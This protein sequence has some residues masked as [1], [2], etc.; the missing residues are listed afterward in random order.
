[1][2]LLL[3]LGE[4]MKF[5]L[6][7]FFVFVWIVLSAAG[8][9]ALEDYAGR[10]AELDAK[11][12]GDLTEVCST[13]VVSWVTEAV[14]CKWQLNSTDEVTPWF[15]ELASSSS[16]SWK[17]LYGLAFGYC[18]ARLV[19]EDEMRTQRVRVPIFKERDRR[20]AVLLMDRAYG[21][22]SSDVATENERRLFLEDYIGILLLERRAAPHLLAEKTLDLSTKDLYGRNDQE[23]EGDPIIFYDCPDSYKTARSDGELIR[24]LLKE[25]EPFIRGDQEP[26]WRMEDFA[27]IVSR[28]NRFSHQVA[29]R[30]GPKE[31]KYRD[32][33]ASLGDDETVDAT[34]GTIVARQLPPDYVYIPVYQKR[35]EAGDR[36]A[37][38]VLGWIFNNRHRLEQAAHCFE[39]AGNT[40][41]VQSI[42]GCQGA[43]SQ[44]EQVTSGCPLEVDYRYRNGTSLDLSIIRWN[45]GSNLLARFRAGEV[46]LEELNILNGEAG[47]SWYYEESLDEKY[48]EYLGDEV[49]RW[50]IA[51][52]PHPDHW[53]SE[54][55]L[56]IPP[57]DAGSYL[58]KTQLQDGN[59][60]INILNVCDTL[61]CWAGGDMILC[62]AATGTPKTDVPVH[63]FKRE[64]GSST[65][66][67]YR[68]GLTDEWGVCGK[69]GLKGFDN[70]VL[71][72]FPCGEKPFVATI[73]LP[74]EWSRGKD[75]QPFVTTDRPVYRPGDTGHLKLWQGDGYENLTMR[76]KKERHASF[77]LP[78][79]EEGESRAACALEFDS[80]GGAG[81]DFTVPEDALP[82]AYRFESEDASFSKCPPIRVEEYRASEM[83]VSARWLEDQ[84][85]EIR[86]ETA[87]GEPVPG[88]KVR[89]RLSF[90]DD[91]DLQLY[92]SAQYD[93]LW[94]RGYWWHGSQYLKRPRQMRDDGYK[95]SESFYF[96]GEVNTNLDADGC[97]VLDLN[98]FPNGL[99]VLKRKGGLSVEATVTDAACRTARM[100]EI[101]P[102]KFGMAT[103]CCHMDR[104]FLE[105]DDD[106]KCDA[107]FDEDPGPLTAQLFRSEGTNDAVEVATRSVVDGKAS[108]GQLPAGLYS[109][110]MTAADGR[111]SSPFEFAVLG[112]A[113][114]ALTPTNPLRLVRASGVSIAGD[115]AEVLIQVDRPGRTVYFFER[116]EGCGFTS[117]PRVIRMDE[118]S[119]V[120]KMQL[121]GDEAGQLHCAA[122]TVVGGKAHTSFSTLWVTNQ[123]VEAGT[124]EI[125][126]ERSGYA[127]GEKVTLN[128]QVLDSSGIGRCG[129]ITVA[130]YNRMLD[131]IAGNVRR[132]D[133]RSALLVAKWDFPS[134]PREYGFPNSWPC[135]GRLAWLLWQKNA[136]MTHKAIPVDWKSSVAKGTGPRFYRDMAL[137]GSD[138]GGSVNLFSMS[139]GADE[140]S[141]APSLMAGPRIRRDFCDTALWEE[142]VVADEDGRAEV[143]FVM[144][145]RLTEWNVM[146]W[147]MHTNFTAV[148]KVTLHS[149]RDFVMHLNTPRF[150]VEG[151]RLELSTALRNHGKTPLLVDAVCV[152]TGAVVITE[153]DPSVNISVVEPDRQQMVYWNVYASGEGSAEVTGT[154]CGGGVS[155]GMAV[156]FPVHSRG[157][158]KRGGHGGVL[159]GEALEGRVLINL[160]MRVDPESVALTLHGSSDMLE[161]VAE[162]LPYL[163]EY[164]HG[165]TEQ[166]LNRFLPSLMVLKAMEKLGIRSL[167]SSRMMPPDRVAIFDPEEIIKRAQA[168]IRALEEGRQSM[169]WGWNL[170]SRSPEDELVT[171]WVLR[172]LYQ[173][174]GHS[175]LLVDSKELENQ[176]ERLLWAVFGRLRDWRENKGR[177]NHADAWSLLV[178]A[179]LASEDGGVRKTAELMFECSDTLPLYEKILL[180]NTLDLI[181]DQEK[182]DELMGFIEQYLE[183]DAVTGSCWL[184]TGD[185]WFW[186]NDAVETQAW[187]LKLL[188][189]TEPNSEKTAGVARY[190]MQNRTYGDHWKSTRDT[191]ICVEALCEF[192]VNNRSPS[193]KA[194]FQ[195]SL[196]GVPIP[197]A[198]LQHGE[199]S[200]LNPGHNELVVRTD[201][202]SMLFFDAT[203]QYYSR[204][205]PISPEQCDLVSVKRAYYRVDSQ[206]QKAE[207][208]P[209]TP[210]DV[211]QAGDTVE[212]ELVLNAAQKLEYLLAED[213][214][215]AGFECSESQ[216]GWSWLL[217]A[218]L[219]LHDERV[220]FYLPNIRQGETKVTYRMRAEHAGCVSALPATVELMYAPSQ[221]ANSDEMKFRIER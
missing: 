60:S 153:A 176:R 15:E 207:K 58:L 118:S 31:E 215:P 17:V 204:E 86:G 143:S 100:E 128:L 32:W 41:I 136:F 66:V 188:N 26:L 79:T 152:A 165:C 155:D 187:Y 194:S 220:S 10:F 97:A 206:M 52:N 119:K 40:N 138:I 147:A 112:S 208:N 67:D 135:L 164:P 146:A 38:E 24:W 34:D 63:L 3:P 144:P 184:R 12:R 110:R 202:G 23:R 21:L 122:M 37:A 47:S 124:V 154:A 81:A 28:V 209:L 35:M 49:A 174:S 211:L 98:A 148:G 104:A 48:A 7:G 94:G 82:G 145:D 73:D 84:R 160:P 77:Y 212:V 16:N 149:T 6:K 127:P 5:C 129:A 83:T 169:G 216:S 57:L 1:M 201:P 72:A 44:C 193:G 65:V 151:D 59:A 173:A 106:V 217:N 210:D 88:G 130:V 214:K 131:A 183:R 205:N 116:A 29:F 219:E 132:M 180:A 141:I 159:A 178:A 103:W 198:V 109:V 74:K 137:Y 70:G 14:R 39:L 56:K 33:V 30:S 69:E 96:S 140:N 20:A 25:K 42:R 181:G 91:Q 170:D 90:D 9:L 196:N 93:F 168:G 61:A 95:F 156:S 36:D 163:A 161:A 133:I 123:E 76:I 179:E 99:E 197:D 189:R 186:Y 195:A 2:E 71:V 167:S 171:A 8:A 175:G 89:V 162:S 108:F 172:G 43:L 11:I 115:V 4:M 139:M 200:G 75:P 158:L 111:G 80:F 120:V 64:R 54:T 46:S 182:R 191:A 102:V 101:L 62:D 117:R 203:W 190:L 218:Y 199:L 55:T 134:E 27:V 185:G 113:D 85:L 18:N 192:I 121:G 107:L 177:M 105:S 13:S 142:T 87:Y 22:L 213:F 78:F 114:F 68:K 125:L 50:T 51:L 221:A 157:M 150:L 166:T 53:D 45:V 19:D 126:S 92:P